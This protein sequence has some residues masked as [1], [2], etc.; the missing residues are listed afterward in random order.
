[1]ETPGVRTLLCLT[2]FQGAPAPLRR[3]GVPS[4][5][6]HVTLAPTTWNLLQRLESS[7]TSHTSRPWRGLSVSRGRPLGR[8]DLSLRT[9]DVTPAPTLGQ[10]LHLPRG[11]HSP[12][13]TPLIGSRCRPIGLRASAV[14]PQVPVRCLRGWVPWT[15]RARR[16]TPTSGLLSP[17][18]CC[19]QSLRV[20]CPGSA[21]APEGSLQPGT[22]AL[23]SGRLLSPRG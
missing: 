11:C 23:G 20:T 13:R 3:P 10:P 19:K 5:T 22:P 14:F 4:H 6:P 1:M 21:F 9:S 17:A 12:R 16:V 8:A 18:P 2:T 15:A 7:L